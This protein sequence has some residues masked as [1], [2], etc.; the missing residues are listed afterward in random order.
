M[1]PLN[2]FERRCSIAEVR[3]SGEPVQLVVHQA[4]GFA[5][6][7]GLIGREPMRGCAAMRFTRCH[8]VHGCFMRRPL[9]IVFLD[10]AGVV[11]SH[12]VL[13]PWR[14]AADHAAIEV[15]EFEVETAERLGLRDATKFIF[16]EK[17]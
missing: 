1:A 2:E 17:G 14:F 10:G 4:R 6:L 8:A 3:V 5:R 7:R 16:A 11:T 9:F 15:L 13:K 12:Q